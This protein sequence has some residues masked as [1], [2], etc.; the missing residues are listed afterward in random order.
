[1]VLQNE[2]MI[3]TW[4]T[5]SLAV[6]FGLLIGS[7][8][9]VVIYRLPI[10]L[11]RQWTNE[12]KA[13]LNLPTETLDRFDLMYPPSRCGHCGSAIRPWQN[14]PLISW[15]Y[16]R[17]R[18]ANCRTSI[19]IRYP[20]VELLTGV[21]FGLMA[22]QYGNTLVTLGACV[23]TA[24]VVA[25]T[26]IDAD[27]QILPDELTLPLIWLGL[28]FNLITGFIPL[29][30][31]VLGAIVGYLSLWSLYHIF[32][33]IT[34]KEGMGYGDFKMLSAIGAWLGLT[35]LPIVVFIAALIGL[36]VAL[37]RQVRKSQPMAFGPCL[38]I[39][40]WLIFLFYANVGTLIRWWFA[41]SGV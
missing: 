6:L 31:A 20:L 2:L 27:E 24:F 4:L 29:K 21:L 38:A 18:C 15:L 30:S 32:K 33:W 41:L 39:A 17:G 25:L 9:N 36:V 5:V 40:A 3:D 22:W 8:L 34:G 1:M 19:S 13:Y 37:I 23:F 16:L 10:I 14:I 11:N 26:F 7:F 35:V 28:L 12:A